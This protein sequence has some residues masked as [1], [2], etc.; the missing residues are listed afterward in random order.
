MQFKFSK[1]ILLTFLLLVL[2]TGL[3]AQTSV[4]AKASAEVIMALTANELASLNFGRFSPESAGGQIILTPDG[5]R[6]STGTVA[7]SGG[8]FNPAMFYISGQSEAAVTIT[9]PSAP[10]VLTNPE[11]GKTM[12]VGD[13]TSNPAQGLGAGV[14]TNG[15]L[16]IAVGATLKVGNRTTNPVGIYT[17]NYAVTFSYN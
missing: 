12:E 15:W 6:T 9:L 3:K 4:N 10:A 5:V 14:L 8:T 13:W 16:N 2:F 11:T 7:L 1:T 17:G